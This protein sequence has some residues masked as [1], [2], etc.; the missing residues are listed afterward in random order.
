MHTAPFGECGVANQHMR[1]FVGMTM[2]SGWRQTIEKT[3]G[4]LQGCTH[5]RELLFNIATAAFQTI[6]H[7]REM[8]RIQ[9][10]EPTQ[11]TPTHRRFCGPVHDVG[12]QWPRGGAAT[13]AVCKACSVT[14]SP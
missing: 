9:R 8:Q 10:G 6:P 12:C 13:A 14:H 2:G 11:T 5:L 4:G 3:I 1:R 7:H